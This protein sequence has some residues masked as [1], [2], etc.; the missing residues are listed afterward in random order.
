MNTYTNIVNGAASAASSS[1]TISDRVLGGVLLITGLFLYFIL[2]IF[3]IKNTV[4]KDNNNKNKINF[5]RILGLV[6]TLGGVYYLI[7]SF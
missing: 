2:D 6:E 4:K 7:K 1:A 5:F 3:K